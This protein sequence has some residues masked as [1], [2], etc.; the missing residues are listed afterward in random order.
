MLR[1]F[2]TPPQIYLAFLASLA[3]KYMHLAI[4]EWIQRVLHGLWVRNF[5]PM[6]YR[7]QGNTS[8]FTC[9]LFPAHFRQGCKVQYTV[10]KTRNGSS[11]NR[12][13]QLQRISISH[14]GCLQ[15]TSCS[16]QTCECEKATKPKTWTWL[17]K[18]ARWTCR[19]RKHAHVYIYMYAA[20]ARARALPRFPFHIIHQ[21]IPVGR[22]RAQS[23][24]RA[25]PRQNDKFLE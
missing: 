18:W 22:P 19:D 9:V 8:P 17:R 5:L 3:Y 21:G 13:E 11:F 7:I 2:P 16:L 1:C 14:P 23:V 15:R 24:W 10:G 6:I 25:R 4:E 20:C 12:D